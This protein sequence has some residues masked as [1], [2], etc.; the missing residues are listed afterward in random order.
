MLGMTL[1]CYLWAVQER[2]VRVQWMCVCV[3][4]GGLAWNRMFRQKSKV[5]LIIYWPT[6]QQA[7]AQR[8]TSC[9]STACI[10]SGWSKPKKKTCDT[11]R[12]GEKRTLRFWPDHFLI[13][14]RFLFYFFAFVWKF[15][16]QLQSV[17]LCEK[18]HRG[19]LIVRVEQSSR[20]YVIPASPSHLFCCLLRR[21]HFRVPLLF[22]DSCVSESWCI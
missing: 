6:G 20:V 10:H 19:Q 3:C 22:I 11:W 17:V 15:N 13:I 5:K 9:I 7:N 12:N 2:P 21:C 18:T 4:E 14:I 16:F 1:A 8:H